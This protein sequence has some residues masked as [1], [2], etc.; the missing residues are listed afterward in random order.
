MAIGVDS[1][2]RFKNFHTFRGQQVLNVSFFRVTAIDPGAVVAVPSYLAKGW[3]ELWWAQTSPQCDATLVYDRVEV[4]EVNGAAIGNYAYVGGQTGQ[5]AG[6]AMPSF[7]AVSV[8]L[9]RGDRTTRHGWKRFAGV[10]ESFCVDGALTSAA[11]TAWQSVI[12]NLYMPTPVPVV[13]V[14]L[15]DPGDEVVGTVSLR[16]IIWGGNDPSFPTGRYQDVAGFD[17][18]GEV[19]TQNTRKIGRGS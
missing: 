7:A 15:V 19:S 3:G 5:V 8:Q 9:L 12:R 4:D 10:P 11:I 17:V 2:I 6:D 14:N 1:I 18:K 13:D 16:A